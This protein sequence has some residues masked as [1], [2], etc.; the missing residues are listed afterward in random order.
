[1]RK[2]RAALLTFLLTSLRSSALAALPAVAAI[3]LT[4]TGCDSFSVL[5]EFKRGFPL[6]LTLQQATLLQGASISLYPTGGRAPYSFGVLAGNLYYSGTLGT[7]SG[8]TYTA[9]TSIGTVIIHLTDANGAT[10]DAVATIVPPTPSGFTV[11][12]NSVTP[13]PNDILVT[14]SYGNTA[15]ISSFTI[16]RS[17]DGITFAAVTS[18]PTSATSWVDAPLTPGTLYYYRMYAVS[19]TYQSF[20]T[21]IQGS[22]P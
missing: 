8:Q 7:I 3:C 19:G 20:D 16:E 14:W 1:V 5:A 13:S 15:F 18:Q 9:G 21:S 10:E 11:Q 4:L 6:S 17:S 22:T 2:L 12:P